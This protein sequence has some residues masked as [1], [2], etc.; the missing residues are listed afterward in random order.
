MNANLKLSHYFARLQE[1]SKTQQ[2][3]RQAYLLTLCLKHF[4]NTKTLIFFNHKKQCKKIHILLALFGIKSAQCHGDMTQKQRMEAVEAFQSGDVNYLLAT[5][6]IGRGLDIYQVQTVIN[7]NFPVDETRYIHRAG[8][9]ARAG[10]SGQCIT[11]ADDDER[12]EVKKVAKKFKSDPKP[13]T[14]HTKALEKIIEAVRIGSEFVTVIQDMEHK[15]YEIERAIMD[16]NKADNLLKYG[17][18]IMNRPRKLWYQTAKGK[19]E[20]KIKTKEQVLRMKEKA[21]KKKAKLLDK[22]KDQKV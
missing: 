7:Y 6:V 14:I 18:D 11:I 13:F 2:Y 9:T 1:D 3:D 4:P 10:L 15:E 17:D 12:K 22:K 5:D 8:R 19:E 16:V 21:L 20:I